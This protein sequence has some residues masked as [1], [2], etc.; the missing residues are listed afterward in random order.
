MATPRRRRTAFP[1]WGYLVLNVVF[2][3]AVVATWFASGWYA[4]QNTFQTVGVA[5]VLAVCWL[6]F[7]VASVFDAV[8]DRTAR[9]SLSPTAPGE[10]E[11]STASRESL[12][13]IEG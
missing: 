3:A 2:L 5:P 7:L 1:L 10:G 4:E 11:G 12:R 6:A 9:S 13:K 8:F